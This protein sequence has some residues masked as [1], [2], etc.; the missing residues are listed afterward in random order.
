MDHARIPHKGRRVVHGVGI[1]L[2]FGALRS[3]HNSADI[4][5]VPVGWAPAAPR[6]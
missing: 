1:M 4:D 5:A 2:G 3:T 6:G